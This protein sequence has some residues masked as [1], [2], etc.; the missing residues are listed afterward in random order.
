MGSPRSAS[1]VISNYNYGRFLGAAIESAL[2][3]S[4]PHTEVIVVDDGSTDDSLD[5]LIP[6]L[7]EIISAI[8]DHGGQSAAVNWGYRLSHGDVIYFLDSDDELEPDCVARTI[9][10]FD[11]ARVAKVH[12]PMRVIDVSGA[13]TGV[14]EHEHLPE[15]DFR[16]RVIRKGPANHRTSSTSANAW[17]R[18]VLDIIMPIPISIMPNA[19][20]AY[21][22]A[23]APFHGEVRAVR[24]PLTRRRRHDRNL[25]NSW[26]AA[27]RVDLWERRAP[28]LRDHLSAFGIE[29][30][31]EDWRANNHYYRQLTGVANAREAIARYIPGDA[32]L[33][34][35]GGG[36]LTPTEI[37]PGR[38]VLPVDPEAYRLGDDTII[39]SSLETFASAA[40]Q[41]AGLAGQMYRPK[42]RLARVEHHV[43]D[44]HDLLYESDAV[45][46]FRLRQSDPPE[47]LSTIPDR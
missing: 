3:Q 45:A 9:D 46:L 24:E 1:I 13:P 41:Y 8:R 7:G 42:E 19:P 31:I 10:L 27:N 33:F 28:L 47:R 14:I 40:G 30:S 37:A 15:G 38:P 21:F 17:A 44:N 12:W 26:T 11:Q 5:V 6:Y 25:S 23:L 22:F 2:A 43:R 36:L 4:Y 29:A 34:W 18:W 16:E 35:I 32:E 20:D 39:L